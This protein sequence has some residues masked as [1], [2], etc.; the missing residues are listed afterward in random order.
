MLAPRLA[1]WGYAGIAQGSDIFERVGR[2]HGRCQL[3]L[4]VTC[5]ARENEMWRKR[6]VI[7]GGLIQLNARVV[8]RGW[9]LLHSR[10][11]TQEKRLAQ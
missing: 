10:E 8:G 5:F 7:D 2:G 1:G 9:I 3:V 4:V 11:W 6:G